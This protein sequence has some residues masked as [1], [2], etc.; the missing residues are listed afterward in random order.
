MNIPENCKHKN[1][2][3]KDCC[4]VKCS[5]CVIVDHDDCVHDSGCDLIVVN[6]RT[7]TVY[8]VEIKSGRLSRADAEDVVRQL[9]ACAE[10]YR[11]LTKNYRVK[12]ILLRCNKKRLD[13]YARE[14]LLRSQLRLL[15]KDC[16]ID[17]SNL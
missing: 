15:I 17:L 8:I 9:N 5:G 14:Y 4:R 11:E 1:S 6:E 12:F 16:N 13:S 7:K 10:Y 3:K 2:Y